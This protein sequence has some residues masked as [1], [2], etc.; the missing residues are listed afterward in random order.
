MIKC[1]PHSGHAIE[2]KRKMENHRELVEKYLELEK[3]LDDLYYKLFHA[4]L[5][6][7]EERHVDKEIDGAIA[8]IE[9]VLEVDELPVGNR[10]HAFGKPTETLRNFINEP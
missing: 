4:F 5:S 6:E 2:Y 3:H 10:I 7:A 9:E 8:Q 1:E